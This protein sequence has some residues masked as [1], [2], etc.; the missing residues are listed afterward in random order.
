MTVEEAAE[1]V[2][3]AGSMNSEGNIFFLDMGKSIKIIDLAKKMIELSGL[4]WSLD[5]KKNADIKIVITGLRPGEKLFEELVIGNAI[6][7][8]TH[9][10]IISI[11]ESFVSLSE[12]KKEFKKINKEKNKNIEI[13]IKK[14]VTNYQG[15]T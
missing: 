14:L 10:K 9:P 1:L 12:L 7:E 6:K 3:Q 8:T 11:K 13:I 5:N 4:T 2:I 15:L